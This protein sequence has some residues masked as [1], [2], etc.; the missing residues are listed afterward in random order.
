MQ[1]KLSVEMFIIPIHKISILIKSSSSFSF[2][3]LQSITHVQ[4]ASDGVVG[5]VAP[6]MAAAELDAVSIQIFWV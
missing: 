3:A 5:A 1:G 6:Q 4:D 2:P